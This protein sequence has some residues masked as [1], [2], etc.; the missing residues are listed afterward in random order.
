[1]SLDDEALT[2]RLVEELGAAL[3]MSLSPTATRVSRW[4]DSFPQFVPAHNARIADVE[5]HLAG[6]LP[7]VAL[8]GASYRG[9]GIPACIASGRRAARQVVSRLLSAVAS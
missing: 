5:S 8:A 4:P 2:S 9:S 6:L 7:T 3:G 1:M